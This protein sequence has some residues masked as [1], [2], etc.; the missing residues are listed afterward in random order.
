VCVCVCVCVEPGSELR[1]S[2]LLGS[3]STTLGTATALVCV[4]VGTFEIDL[5]NHHPHDL[6]LLSRHYL[7]EPG[8]VIFFS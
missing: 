3:H 6:Y 5:E 4:H 2:S 8:S 1:A 7:Q